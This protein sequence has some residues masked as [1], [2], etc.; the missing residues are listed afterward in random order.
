MSPS[1]DATAQR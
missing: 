1:D